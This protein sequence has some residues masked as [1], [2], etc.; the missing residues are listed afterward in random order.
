MFMVLNPILL[1]SFLVLVADPYLIP[2]SALPERLRIT[3]AISSFSAC[4]S[5]KCD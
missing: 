5:G 4:E 3:R 1:T 2:R